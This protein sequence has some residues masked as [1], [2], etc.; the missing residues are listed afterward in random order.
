M[1]P[2][3]K[4][5]FRDAIFKTTI[6]LSLSSGAF[7]NQ[8]CWPRVGPACCPTKMTDLGWSIDAPTTKLLFVGLIVD[9]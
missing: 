3:E 6:D 7:R 4:M 5:G 1:A 9:N 8:V 2:E